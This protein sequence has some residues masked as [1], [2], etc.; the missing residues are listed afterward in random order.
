MNH[1]NEVVCIESRGSCSVRAV[2][3]EN[4]VR[5]SFTSAKSKGRLR[6]WKHGDEYMLHLYNVCIFDL[7]IL[8]LSF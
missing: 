8:I 1:A 5:R 4:W 2:S 3:P 6:R 7:H